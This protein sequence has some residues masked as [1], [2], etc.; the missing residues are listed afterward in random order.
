MRQLTAQDVQFLDFEAERNPPNFSVLAILDPSTAPGGRLDLE[1]VSRLLAERL[2]LLPPFTW[3]LAEVPFGL[4]RPYW[5]DDPS[6]D[7]SFHV[8]EV[9]LPRPGDDRAL[10]DLVA[11]IASKPLDRTRP[12]WELYLINRLPDGRV[13]LLTKMHHAA[14]DG[15]SATELLTALY[16]D[17]PD[18][19]EPAGPAVGGEPRKT[20]NDVEMLARGI[21]SLPVESLRAVR[22][23]AA[24]VT[25]GGLRTAASDHR[26]L[27]ALK[28]DGDVLQSPLRPAPQTRFNDRIS[29]QRLLALAD[30]SLDD[31]KAVKDKLGFTVNDVV[32]ALCAG[33]LRDLLLERQELP[34][35]PL[36]AAVPVS[37]RSPEHAGT[38]GN[39]VSAMFVALP[40]DE[41]DA[42]RRLERAHDVMRGAKEQHGA[43]PVALLQ[44]LAN[45]TPAA[46]NARAG[47][48]MLRLADPKKPMYN[49]VISNIP[50][51]SVPLYCGGA[52][53]MAQY[54]VSGIVDG[55]GLNI[56]LMS[57]CGRL[58][59]GIVV[60]RDHLEDAWPLARGL[61]AALAEYTRSL[62]G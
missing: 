3:K 49:C 23:L 32:I 2:H 20:P 53:L 58:H 54:P 41:P 47:R 13:G 30:V 62:T 37:I 15:V 18:A 21:L 5:V 56:T 44:T 40:T 10:A 6:F 42:W 12:L 52:R 43:M 39:R 51:S 38:F 28:R 34:D 31:V 61:E 16:D 35:E 46:L 33:A 55:M 59:F 9:T 26:R 48:L 19:P 36:V 57:Y 60:A 25:G 27:A 11:G 8:R 29:G 1:A 17:R 22:S 7:L 50:G 4:A 24:G 14:V 45:A